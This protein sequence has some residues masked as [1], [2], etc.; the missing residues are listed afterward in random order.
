MS[1]NMF[2]DS[3]NLHNEADVEQFFVIRLLKDLHYPDN[4][5]R[6][7]TSLSQLTIGGLRDI[8]KSSYKPDYALKKSR[9]IRWIVE[10]KAPSENLNNHVWQPKGYCMLLNGQYSN[11]NPVQYYVLTNSKQTR[12]Y[13]WDVNDPVLELK[14]EDFKASNAKYKKFKD[15]LD[16]NNITAVK[17]TTVKDADFCITKQDIET[18]NSAFLWCHQ[19]IYKKDNI[20]QGEAFSEFVKI[21]ALKLLSDKKI[22]EKYPEIIAENEVVVPENDV[23]FSSAWIKKEQSVTNNPLSD[24]RFM[25]F[26]NEMEHDIAL[27]ER[28]RIFDKG[29]KINLKPETILGVV[30]KLENLY[31]YDI[32]TDLN[33]RLFETFL[34]ATMRGKDLGQFF[35]PRSLVKLGVELA[36][37]KV[38]ARNDDGTYHTDT[39]I[40]AC[41]GTGGFLIDVFGEMNRQISTLNNLSDSE[42]AILKDTVRTKNI[43]G[44]DIGK[45][46]NLSRVARLNMYLHGD[47]GTKIYN[48]DALD[49]NIQVLSDDEPE[50]INE[51]QEFVSILEQKNRYFDIALTN[52]PFAK[53]YE[54]SFASDCRIL[55]QYEIGTENLDDV[56]EDNSDNADAMVIQDD[57][58]EQKQRQSVKSSLL[59]IERYYDLLKAG[60]RLITIIDDG[61][62]SGK[63]YKWFRDYI[64]LHFLIRAVISLPGDAFQRSKARIKT[65]FLV[66]EKRQ[67][68]E[69]DQPPV[70]MYAC[71]YIGN[72]DPSRQR[73]MPEDSK[74]RQLASEEID[75]VR[76]EYIKF[77]AG[78]GASKYIVP[79]NKLL[80]RMDV[81]NCWIKT[82]R[83]VSSWKKRGYSIYKISDLVHTKDFND[84]SIIVTGDYEGTVTPIIVRYNGNLEKDAELNA[85]D[86]KYSKLYVVNENDIVISNIAASYGSVGVI[87]RDF[88]GCVVSNEYTVLQVNKP[89]DARVVKALLRTPEIRSEILLASTGA[90]RTRMHWSNIKNIKIIYP[91]PAVE[92]NMI[93]A[94][95][96]VEKLEAELKKLKNKAESIAG[97]E[98]EMDNEDA[99]NI[100]EAF[101]PPK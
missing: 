83:K 58:N 59:F 44:I 49:K 80:D 19:H 90:N 95:E 2:C 27:G 42:K 37:I 73:A 3:K 79:G 7:K 77:L 92:K 55:D 45:G 87:T 35:T 10:V 34:N 28:K 29:E 99:L 64:R 93:D 61:I 88:D 18:V 13:K 65:S 26:V 33:G 51:K 70:F 12:I 54:R 38:H 48:F 50:M 100:L 69:Q 78:K 74:T 46:P 43:V 85:S 98:Y 25:A 9:R 36:Q 76:E 30:K 14:F 11:N 62:L 40:D 71:K 22:K 6:P 23:E 1:V 68:Y 101:K 72:D 4:A 16:W 60:G 5:I 56:I 20:S 15:I 63:D 21:I 89:F 47:G 52:P 57:E 86:S 53:V 75:I 67:D 31:L 91:E 41:C 17:E 82:G 81:K 94:E 8:P 84:G 66:L 32:D 24:I 97:K 96:K 39:V